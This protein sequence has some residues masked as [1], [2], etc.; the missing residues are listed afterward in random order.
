MVL[1]DFFFPPLA[2][3]MEVDALLVKTSPSPSKM[4]RRAAAVL[5]KYYC[6][7]AVSAMLSA[8]LLFSVIRNFSSLNSPDRV[9]N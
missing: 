6:V 3:E 1:R 2:L 5:V 9:P 8:Y 4:V 7:C